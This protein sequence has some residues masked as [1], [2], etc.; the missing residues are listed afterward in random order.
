M[1]S[2]SARPYG[3]IKKRTPNDPLYYLLS[4]SYLVLTDSGGIQEEVLAL[5]KPVLVM[6]E[7]KERPEGVWGKMVKLG[8]TDRDR[9]F[10]E[11]KEL[12]ENPVSYQTM[13]QGRNPYGDGQAAGRIAE[14]SES[15]LKEP[16]RY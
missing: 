1:R 8:G 10:Q 2:A 13:A 5:G 14:I 4:Q 3:N 9:S 11:I 16:A 7:V 15:A 6:Q 12:V